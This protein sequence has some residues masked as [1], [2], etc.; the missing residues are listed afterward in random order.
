MKFYSK[1]KRE[2][3]KHHIKNQDNIILALLCAQEISPIQVLSGLTSI[4]LVR[5]NQ[6]CLAGFNFC[7]TYYTSEFPLTPKHLSYLGTWVKTEKSASLKTA[8][9]LITL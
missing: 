3:I 7:S 6:V 9:R 8:V 5:Q 1:V 4:A 2:T